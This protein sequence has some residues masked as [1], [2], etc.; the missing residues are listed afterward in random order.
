[1]SLV[2]I[3]AQYLKNNSIVDIC[4]GIGFI[5]VAL[6]LYFM[7]PVIYPAK[8][9]VSILILI[10]G[11]RLTWYIF[12]RNYGKGEDFRYVRFRQDW[13]KSFLVKSF[14]F[15]FMLQ[16]I[17]MLIISMPVIVIFNSPARALNFFDIAGVIVFAAGFFFESAG[18]YQ[19]AQFKKNPANKGRLMTGGLWQHT[20]HPN[21]FGEAVMW[22]GIFL[23][24]LSSPH[25]WIALISP[26]LITYLLVFVSGVP[27]LEKKY[28]G[29]PDFEE[30]KKNT[31]VFVPF[32]KI[33]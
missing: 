33:K 26:V 16:G 11:A 1:M 14:F 19:L 12:L 4:W 13:G 24:G 25:G 28:A 5:I 20:R 9:I 2:F 8:I 17:L 10:W 7:R 32:I 18:D 23:I 22:W 21:Y 15:I 27:L 31:P 3:A 30:Y 6:S 29:R